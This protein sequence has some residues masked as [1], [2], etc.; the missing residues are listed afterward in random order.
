MNRQFWKDLWWL[1]LYVAG[2]LVCVAVLVTPAT[3]LTNVTLMLHLVQWAQTVVLMALPPLLW[4][5]YY[6]KEPVAEALCLRRPD[7]KVLLLV[8]AIMVAALPWMDAL[9]TLCQQIHYPAALQE[10]AEAS[11]AEQQQAIGQL[12]AVS[13]VG[14]WLELILL[15][16]VGTAIGEELMFRGA[17]TRCFTANMQ[18]TP[19][20]QGLTRRQMIW[21]AIWVGLTFSVCHFDLMGFI[22]RWLL[23]SGFVLLVMRTRSLWPA[24]LAHAVN[25]LFALIETRMLGEDATMEWGGWL[26]AISLVATAML[27]WALYSITSNVSSEPR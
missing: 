10:W 1:L 27:V 16:C 24:V 25:N 8:L 5:R 19:G 21:T 12:L 23:G 26:V 20:K 18:K 17:L 4:A 14:G 15:M 11:Y 2:G 3:Q 6:K 22:P 7:M 13:G 9:A